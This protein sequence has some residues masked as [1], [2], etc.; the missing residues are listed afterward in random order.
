MSFCPLLAFL[1][2]DS[3]TDDKFEMLIADTSEFETDFCELVM[4]KAS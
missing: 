2:T 3:V 4:G 1:I